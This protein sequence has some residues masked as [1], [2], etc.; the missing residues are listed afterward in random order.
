MTADEKSGL[1]S[2]GPK[3]ELQSNGRYASESIDNYETTDDH[4]MQHSVGIAKDQNGKNIISPTIVRQYGFGARERK[5]DQ[6]R[7]RF[8]LE[9]TY[10]GEQYILNLIDTPGHV[11]F[12]MKFPV[13]LQLVKNCFGCKLED[14]IHAS[15]KTGFG[16]DKILEAIVERVPAPK[17]DPEEPLQALIFDSVYNPFRGIEVIFRV[18]N[19]EIKKNQKIKFMATGNEYYADEI[20]TLKLNQVPKQVISTGDVGYLISGIKEA[21]EVKVGDTITDA[22]TPTKNMIT[23]FEDVKPMVFCR[24]LS[25]RL[26]RL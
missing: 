9:Y 8:R 17:G 15:G 24:N 23:G 11:D 13:Q 26:L 10:K 6:N 21:K 2:N 7:M 12:L 20:G 14:I 5:Y 16:V 4:G 1:C 25:G 3:P 19:G 18:I 22:A